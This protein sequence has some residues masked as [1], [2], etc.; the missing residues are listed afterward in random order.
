M[1]YSHKNDQGYEKQ[2][3]AEMKKT[4]KKNTIV[5][6][7]AGKEG[8][9]AADDITGNYFRHLKKRLLVSLVVAFLVPLAV[10]SAYFHIQFNLM[11]KKSGTQ[12]LV[13]LAESQRNTIDLFLQ[14]RV[15]N[16]FN[17]FHSEDFNVRPLQQDVNTCLQHLRE[18]NDAFVDVGFFNNTG[19]QI[20]YSGPYPFLQ[21]KDYSKEHWFNILIK[22]DKNYYI[23]DIYLGFR[24]KPHFTIAVKQPVGDNF[25]V[26]RA[27]LDPDKFYMFLRTIGKGKGV[28][29]S[30][31]NR[32]GLYQIVD[33]DRGTLLGQSHFNPPVKSG[34]GITEIKTSSDTELV[35]CTWL[36]QV[37]WA[38]IVSQPLG[39]A[40]A[41][42]YKIRKIM[43]GLTASVVIIIFIII[44]L[45]TSRLL[46]RAETME[47]SRRELKSQLFHA[48]KLV[49]VG[50][51]AAGIAHEIN[52]PL[53]IILSQCGV[54][55]DIFDPQFGGNA[56]TNPDTSKNVKEE[57]D[58]V[59]EAVFRARDITQKLLKSARKSKPHLDKYNVNN[60]LDDVVSGLLEREFAVSNIELIREYDP[61][62]PQ[63]LLDSDQIYQVFQNLVNNA[64]DAIQGPGK[65]TLTTRV[66]DE[67]VQVIV[68]DTGKGIT[69]E[70]MGKIFLPFF[71]TKEVGKGTGLGLA[72][73][74]SIV[75]AM[76][77]S[78][79]VQS[80]PE[81]GTA[82]TVSLPISRKEE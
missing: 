67:N 55:R 28:S 59:E 63:I 4:D 32:T 19:L 29:V 72:I 30:L 77:G 65:I 41:Q 60:I 14:E 82:F 51:L 43:V 70:E 38:L 25:L 39:I 52:N 66:K 3:G 57:L 6:D 79:D 36:S 23:S 17:L 49:S 80:M 48:T 26:V 42:M 18:A 20:G 76:G 15:V 13:S 56:M 53:A 81:A 69:Q 37:P 21:G 12:H 78:I 47:R 33:P 46:G 8:S 9:Q 35:A 44:W 34:S 16:I 45:S 5:L 73:S 61:N 58:I 2:K 7:K 68:S 10:L 24:N 64:G 11:L 27:T 22:Q 74:L 71:T 31:I 62:L 1:R 54:I 75:E 50:E 40:Y